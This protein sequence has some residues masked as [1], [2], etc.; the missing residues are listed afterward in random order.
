MRDS[1]NHEKKFAEPY[2]PTWR[3][4]ATQ[5]LRSLKIGDHIVA[6]VRART[7][8]NIEILDGFEEARL[9]YL[10]MRYSLSDYEQR[11]LFFDIGGRSTEIIDA[12]ASGII[13]SARFD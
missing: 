5:S 4:I 1:R 7:Q 9:S 6:K 3:I 12:T 11:F 2:K 10:G 8:L 13:K